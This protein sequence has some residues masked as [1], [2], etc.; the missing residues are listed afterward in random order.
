[1]TSQSW[2]SL[3]QRKYQLSLRLFLFLNATSAVFSVTNP[4]YSVRVFSAPLIAIFFHQHRPVR[5]ALEKVCAKDKYSFCFRDLRYFVGM[6][7]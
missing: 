6:A 5:L 1:M 4:L 3:V 7:N 2:R